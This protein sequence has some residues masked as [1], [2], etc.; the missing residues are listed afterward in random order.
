MTSNRLNPYIV[1]LKIS[2]SVTRGGPSNA[3]NPTLPGPFSL[4][5]LV[6][7]QWN[8]PRLGWVKVLISASAAR[9]VEFSKVGLGEGAYIGIGIEGLQGREE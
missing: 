5:K 4:Q 1:T 7:E 2:A 9:T 8:S 6:P 3:H